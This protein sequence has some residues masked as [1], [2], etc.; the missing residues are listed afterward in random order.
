M[1]IRVVAGGDPPGKERGVTDSRLANRDE[2]SADGPLAGVRVLDL[3]RVLAGPYATMLLGDAGAEVVK[4]AGAREL[5]KYLAG[6][7]EVH[8]AFVEQLFHHLVKQPVRAY[9]PSTAGGP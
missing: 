2:T 8:D 4:F 1:E 5:A 9:G 6:S 3:T 7:S